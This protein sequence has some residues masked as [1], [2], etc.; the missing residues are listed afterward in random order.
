MAKVTYTLDEETVRTIRKMAERARKPQSL[1]VRE[2]VAHYAAAEDK[3]SPDEQ[4]RLLS[5]LEDVRKT[6]PTRAQAD[7][8]KEL[9]ELRK[10]RRRAWTRPWEK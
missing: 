9:R 6:L 3:L 8:D 5:V 4:A 10:A 2:A 1:V 7:V